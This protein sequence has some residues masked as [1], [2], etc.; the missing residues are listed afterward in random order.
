MSS[1]EELEARVAQ[2]EELEAQRRDLVLGARAEAT[3]Y[4][5]GLVHADTQAIRQD[6]TELRAE[7]ATRQDLDDLSARMATREDVG[8]LRAEVTRRFDELGQS[9][10]ALLERLPEREP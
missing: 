6:V 7:A 2:L 1:V 3:A 8:D 9:M 5:L 4:G 10:A